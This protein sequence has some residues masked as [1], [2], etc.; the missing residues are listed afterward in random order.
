MMAKIAWDA[1]GTHFFETGVDHCVLY[2]QDALGTYLT[3]YPWNGVTAITESP[4]GAE[5]SPQYADNIK[6]LNL[7]SAEEAGFTLEAFTYPDKFA[8][9]DGSAEPTPGVTF[10]QQARKT[11]GLSYRTK[12][13]NDVDGVDHGYKLHLVWGAMAAPSEKARNTINES[14]EPMTFSWEITTTP[15]AVNG[16]KPTAHMVIDSTKVNADLLADLEEA[17][18][19]TDGTPGTTGHLPTPDAVITMLTPVAP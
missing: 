13:G 6:Y 10:G 11:F 19:G 3:A 7:Y 9:C 4:S 15:V 17:L 16:Y 2:P 5:P 12:I 1:V 14:Q 8:E 18:Y